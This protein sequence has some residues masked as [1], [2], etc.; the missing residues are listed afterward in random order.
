MRLPFGSFFSVLFDAVA[1]PRQTLVIVRSLTFD[2]L[3]MIL[4]RGDNSRALP[5]RDPRVRALVWELKYHAQPYAAA[6]AGEVVAEVLIDIASEELGKPLLV[7]MP[8]HVIRRRKRGHNQAELLCEAALV[9]CEDFFDYAPNVLVRERPTPPQ[10]GLQKH[11]RL[12]NVKYSMRVIGQ[13]AGK[14]AGRMCIVVDDV[15]TTGASFTEARR[16]LLAAGA[17][18]VECVALAHS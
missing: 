11:E 10:Q 17:R 15:S 8:M 16:A 1:P 14:V 7:P 6:L 5:Y 13:D 4:L 12:Q 2:E 9:Y 18:E 3:R